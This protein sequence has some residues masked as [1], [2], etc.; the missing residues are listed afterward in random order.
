M[1]K[2]ILFFR[3]NVLKLILNFKQFVGIKTSTFNLKSGEKFRIRNIDLLGLELINGES[4][5]ENTKDLIMNTVKKGMV[6]LDIGANI[7][8][9]TVKMASIVGDEG[10]VLAF[11]PNP[12]MVKELK[13]NIELNNL[14]NV[15]IHE[16]ALSNISGSLTFYNPSKG[17]EAHGSLKQ[18]NTFDFDDTREVRAE[19]LDD[20]LKNAGIQKVDFIKIDVEGA[21]YEVLAGAKE[22]LFSE[23]KPVIIFESAENLCYAFE[24]K[25][26]DILKL[27][28]DYGYEIENIDWGNWIATPKKK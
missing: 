10:K 19:R 6:V 8:Y 24:H 4:F 18:N 16:I 3:R 5:E 22:L 1:K 17:K 7:G 21:E 23:N 25:V 28:S 2:I 15:Q 9:Y 20:V 12:L 27:V 11:E 26:F 13:N 14:K